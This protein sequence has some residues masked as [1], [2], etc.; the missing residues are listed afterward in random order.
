MILDQEISVVR[1]SMM[2]IKT[3]DKKSTFQIDGYFY[4][5][6]L[7]EAYS[8]EIWVT[9]NNNEW[10]VATYSSE[11]K[12]L[13]VIERM[14]KHLESRAIKPD[15]QILSVAFSLPNQ[16]IFHFPKEEDLNE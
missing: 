7:R 9:N 16:R 6:S 13:K 8:H 5:R 10:L 1:F 4:R 3:Q 12:C 2:W 15:N 11:E 14:D